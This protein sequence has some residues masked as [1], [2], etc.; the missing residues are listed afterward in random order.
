MDHLLSCSDQTSAAGK[1]GIVPSYRLTRF[2]LF[3]HRAIGALPPVW[4]EWMA[5]HFIRRKGAPGPAAEHVLQYLLS[6]AKSAKRGRISREATI[7]KGADNFYQSQYRQ[8]LNTTMGAFAMTATHALLGAGR[9]PRGWFFGRHRPTAAALIGQ[10]QGNAPILVL[11][12]GTVAVPL[13]LP[14]LT[15]Q[16]EAAVAQRWWSGN[17][18]MPEA[19]RNLVRGEAVPAAHSSVK[20]F[21]RDAVGTTLEV[22]EALLENPRLALLALH[23]YDPDAMGLHITLYGVELLAP[24][25]LQPDYGL[26]AEV[27]S[28]YIKAAQL[29]GHKLLFAVGGTEEVFTQC[30]QNLFVKRPVTAD[31]VTATSTV[32][33]TP[34]QPLEDLLQS[35]F[36][37]I[38]I[39]VSA[40]GLPGAS[41][42]NG[43]KGKAAFACMHKEKLHVLI[44]YHPGN[45]IHGHAAKLWSNPY[46]MLVIS[47]DH[48]TLS[49]VIISGASTTIDQQQVEKCFPEIAAEV[50]RQRGRT[51]KPVPVPEYWFL[52]EVSELICQRE[53]LSA[54]LLAPGRETCSISAGGQARHNKKPAY[55]AAN[56]LPLY[57]REWQH[58]REAAGRPMDPKGVRI[59]E[60]QTTVAEDL[61]A[62]RAHL[63]RVVSEW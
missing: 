10:E 37:L 49:R 14:S 12:A 44:P 28:P 20:A 41:P 56:N 23:P 31:V 34:S 24:E 17:G 18:P 4:R 26:N 1:Q 40:S 6:A 19:Y 58:E 8:Q 33:W 27:I 21:E 22:V 57:D 30:S 36:E 11:D 62:R 60:W 54:N 29:S 9:K 25:R 3:L 39:T 45:Y 7:A 61:A 51:G 38:Q 46:G 50:A 59:L 32:V 16:Q 42:R 2:K 52:Q 15:D 35:Q 13:W 63:D 55:F 53:R 47:D 43:D 5:E 48:A